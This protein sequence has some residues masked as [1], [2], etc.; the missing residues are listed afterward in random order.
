MNK[1]ILIGIFTVLISTLGCEPIF[2]FGW[3][4]L[5]F[6]FLLFAFLLGPPL[7]RFIRRVEKFL[8]H[9]KKE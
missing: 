2:A 9:E 8:K 3:K 6:V 4:E 5:F 1:R 7:Y